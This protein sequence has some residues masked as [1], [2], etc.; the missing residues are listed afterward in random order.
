M[1]Q[2]SSITSSIQLIKQERSAIAG[3]FTEVFDPE[4]KVKSIS[5]QH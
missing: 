4:T 5:I 1:A 2:A 3:L